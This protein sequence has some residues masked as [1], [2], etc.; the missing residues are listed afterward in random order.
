[1]T[2]AQKAE[3]ITDLQELNYSVAMC[4]D[5]SNDSLA[6]SAADVSLS[7]SEAETSFAAQFSSDTRHCMAT[8]IM[9]SRA[10]LEKILHNFKFIAIFVLL[11]MG[12]TL[13]NNV[14]LYGQPQMIWT[15]AVKAFL[16]LIASKYF[17]TISNW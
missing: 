5:G 17:V 10:L 6:L 11:Q 1:M 7:I 8:L 15:N 12:V 4:G 9:D 13:L 2:P 3:L 14:R 16:L